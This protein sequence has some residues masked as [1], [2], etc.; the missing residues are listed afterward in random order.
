[1]RTRAPA[2]SA[3]LGPGFDCAAVA[4]DLWN[5]VEV[6]EGT[7]DPPDPTHIGIRAFGL[8]ASPEGLAFEWTDQIPR[9]RGL[10]SS[11]ATIVLGLVAAA[12]WSGQD[13]EL[14][15]LLARGGPLEGHSDN[16]AACLAGGACLTWGGRIARLADSLPLT[17]V[18][19]IPRQLVRTAEA[20]DALPAQVPYVDAS[21]NVARTALLG[22][23]LARGDASLLAAAFEDRLHEPYR[24]SA[25]LDAIR[26][27]LPRGAVGATLSGSGPTVIAWAD[28]AD[29][30]AADLAARF[31]DETVLALP[32]SAKGAH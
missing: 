23:G 26:A 6:S 32:V 7:G 29:S 5:E 19:V 22:A 4:L 27:D 25:L 11:A 12:K 3:N 17:P 10:G 13:L 28:D 21:F 30:C 18:A 31:P 2:T 8:V 20:R 24:P 14:E 16:L 9:A 1:M 15:D